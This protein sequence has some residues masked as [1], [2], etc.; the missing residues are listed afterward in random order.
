MSAGDQH[1]APGHPGVEAKWSSSAKSAVGTALTAESRVWFTLGR[2]ILNEVYYP[3]IDMACIRD[4]GLLVTGPD[5]FFSEEKRDAN[6][7]VQSLESGIPAI[8]LVNTCIRGRYRITKGVVSDPHRDVLLQHIRFEALQGKASDYRVYLLLAPHLVNAGNH[9]SAWLG[10]YKGLPLAFASGGGR[11]LALG[12]E[13]PLKTRSVGFVGASDGWRD[14]KEHGELTDLYARASDGNVALMVELDIHQPDGV[15]VALGFG[16]VSDEAAFRVRGSLQ[17]GFG[18]ALHGYVESWRGALADIYDLKGG[19]RPSGDDLYK[20]DVSVLLTHAPVGYRGAMIASL[21]IPWGQ[22]KGDD[23]MGGYHLVWPRDLVESAGGLLAAGLGTA[24]LDVLHFLQATQEADG[25]WPQN[26]WLDGTPY[27]KGVQLDECAFPILLVDAL[28]R[29][30]ITASDGTSRY[31][32]MV[33]RAVSF[34]VRNG[35]ITA[36]DRWEEDSGFSPFTLAVTVSALLAAAELLERHGDEAAAAYLRDNADA[37]NDAL[38]SW[39]YVTGSALA[40]AAGVPGH[41]VR[42]A[43]VGTA[44]DMASSE[45]MI[46]NRGG[47]VDAN[48]RSADIVSPDALALVRFGLRAADDPRI[49]HT[50]AVID[51]ELKVELPQGPAWYR[52]NEDGY[53]EHADGTAFDGVGIGRPWPL[54]TGERAHYEIAAGRIGEARALLANM[55]K[56]ANRGGLLPEQVWDAADV[57]AHLL[58]RGRPSGS[59]MPLVWAHSEHLKLLRSLADGAI[60]DMPPLTAKRYLEQKVQARVALWRFDLPVPTLPPGRALRIEVLAPVRVHG[61]RD[62][63]ATTFDVDAVDTGFGTYIVDLAVDDAA[64]LRFTFFW[65]TDQ[66]WEGRDFAVAVQRAQ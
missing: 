4:A 19:R 8:R 5:G 48:H 23:D 20:V 56:S 44:G 66:R 30:N 16:T 40:Q 15:L 33:R 65:T 24:A 21:S 27:W 42:I 6:H 39:T 61:T 58:F 22:S 54:L 49:V 41:Y 9:N 7:A 34:I 52:Y 35:P 47:G 43:A 28:Q 14:L 18:H 10:D 38:E 59:A 17:N 29:A 3:R 53:G 31:L 45:V 62:D 13:P 64:Q 32:T 25:R 57:P 46:R 12:A 60:F 51:H 50:V 55:E 26:M 36:Q 63:W 2:G 11:S 1:E 37:I